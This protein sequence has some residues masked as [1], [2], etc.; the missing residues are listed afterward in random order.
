MD[1]IEQMKQCR[2]KG[3]SY[4]KIGGLFGITRQR[5]HQLISGYGRLLGTHGNRGIYDTFG[6]TYNNLRLAVFVRDGGHCQ[7]CGGN[8]AILIHHLDGDDNNN[9][10]DNLVTMCA[11]CH[12]ELHR[13]KSDKPCAVCGD[14]FNRADVSQYVYNQGLCANC[15]ANLK[16]QEEKNRLVDF[17]CEVCNNPFV[18]RRRL[19][20]YRNRTNQNNPRFCS[21]LCRNK[22]QSMG[23]PQLTPVNS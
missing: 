6:K 2:D 15:W 20:D 19:V 3:F 1:R 4:G 7:K 22:W 12:L 10:I 21:H 9:I 5:A 16:V 17:T 8:G 13:P 18:V 11:S 14:T 23:R